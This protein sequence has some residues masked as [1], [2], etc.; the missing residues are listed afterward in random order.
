MANDLQILLEND[1]NDSED[2]EIPQIANYSQVPTVFVW[3]K[4]GLKISVFRNVK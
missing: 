2:E 4:R 3:P 1:M